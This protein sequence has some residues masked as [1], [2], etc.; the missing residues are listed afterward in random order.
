MYVRMDERYVVD[1]ADWLVVSHLSMV[2]SKCQS[3]V[4]RGMPCSTAIRSVLRIKTDETPRLVVQ[5]MRD[6]DGMALTGMGGSFEYQNSGVLVDPSN[7]DVYSEIE[8]MHYEHSG[9]Q[10]GYPLVMGSSSATDVPYNVIVQ[11]SMID[12]P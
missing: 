2:L 10:K 5:I 11:C 8:K 7:F 9:G 1:A 4:L 3:D 6:P 12:H